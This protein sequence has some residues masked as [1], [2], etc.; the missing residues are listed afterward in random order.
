MPELDAAL[1]DAREVVEQRSLG[2]IVGASRGRG[3]IVL[4]AIHHSELN[5]MFEQPFG[6]VEHHL[7]KR[8]AGVEVGLGRKLRRLMDGKNGHFLDERGEDVVLAL[9]VVVERRTADPQ[10]IRDI[11][12][13]G[14]PESAL[15]EQLGSRLEHGAP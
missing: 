15:C 2:L 3:Q 9:E 8:L 11:L 5:R 12:K 6:V 14:A 7:A 4:C 13:I 1:D 10:R